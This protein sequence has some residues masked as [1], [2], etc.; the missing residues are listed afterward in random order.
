M[1]VT[2]GGS[3]G[4]D[5]R[6][7]AKEYDPPCRYMRA[8]WFFT[9]MP[10]G[11]SGSKSS[12]ITSKSAMLAVRYRSTFPSRGAATWSFNAANQ[13]TVHF[14]RTRGG[15]GGR[16]GAGV[17]PRFPSF[18][19]SATITTNLQNGEGLRR[20]QANTDV[21]SNTHRRTNFACLL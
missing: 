17:Y 21:V 19:L 8:T 14:D 15:E 1:H 11:L 10:I 5:L 20:S 2:E 7:V 16:D 4:S 12:S 18:K 9:W 3:G 13:S 6:G